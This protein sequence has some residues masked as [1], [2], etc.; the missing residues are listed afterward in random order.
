MT[1]DI[2]I[3]G[4]FVAGLL[5]FLSPCVLPL[6]PGYLSFISGVNLAAL[7]Q[8][9]TSPDQPVPQTGAV[10]LNAL[11]FVLGF[12]AV[13]VALGASATALGT[14]M[15]AQ[16]P[17]LSKIAGVLLVLF[18][19]HMTGLIP[20]KALYKEKRFQ[21][22]NKPLGL[23]GAF[24]VGCAFAFG[25]TPCIGPI[26]AGIL[27]LAASSETINQGIVLLAAYSAGL[28]V[29]F[30][31]AALLIKQ[32]YAFFD[33]IK[34]HFRKVEIASGLLLVVVGVLIYTGRL[35]ELST[36]LQGAP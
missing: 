36:Y 17:L 20:I 12:S 21:V 30:L 5:S 13:F 23:V 32:F 10:F 25:W 18:G 26:L 7:R 16:L 34:A 8:G 3:V 15:L 33:S 19:L 27:T 29:P 6:V 11:F 1:P 14:Q 9:D 24:V 28:G 22:T 31:L 4:A 2:G 35:T